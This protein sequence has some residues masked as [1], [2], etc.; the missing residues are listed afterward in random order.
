MSILRP[1]FFNT[2]LALVL[3]SDRNVYVTGWSYGVGTGTDYAT[4]KYDPDGNEIWVTRYDG[5]PHEND[6]S[7]AIA[8]DS[9]GNVYVTGYSPN[10]GSWDYATIKYSPK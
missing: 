7:N 3:D 2:L 5:P 1:A 4:V 6:A 10:F 9:K 8:I